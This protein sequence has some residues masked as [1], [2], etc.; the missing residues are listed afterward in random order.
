MGG[1][2]LRFS[3]L[4]PLR[5]WY[6]DDEVD[7]GRPQQRAVLAALLTASG[8]TVATSV[9]AEGVWGGAPPSEPR[10]AVQLHVSR[11]RAAFK[12]C[13]G[14]ERAG[15][16]LVRVGDGYA[17][18]A[19]DA[20][21]DAVVWDRLLA[22]AERL[23][24]EGAPADGI[25]EV[26]LRA[27]RLWDG[28]PLAG[29]A[30]PHAESVR[31][32]LLE[33]WLRAKE[34][35]L[36]MD[37]ELGDRTDLTAEAASL[38]LEHPGRPRLTA[39]LMRALYQAGRKAE[40]LAVYE[41]ARR[42]LPP[43]EP[44]AGARA[45]SGSAPV[46]DP[47]RAG[48]PV[49]VGGGRRADGPA[50]LHLRILREDPSLLPLSAARAEAPAWQ[51]PHQLP[52][53]LAD[54]TG[55]ESAVELLVDRLVGGVGR[56]VV[57]SALDGMGGV[58]K[59]TLAV[60]VARRVHER[61]PDGQLFADLRGADRAPLDPG[62]ALAR[63]LGALGVAASE[64][65]LDLGERSALYR[66]ALAGRKVLVVLDNAAGPEQVLPLLPGS[67]GCAVLITSRTRLTGLA[68]AHQMRLETLEPDEALELFT[69]IAG[70]ERVAA[71]PGL[72]EEIVAAC[73]LLPLAVRIVASRLAADPAL[74]LAA[75]SAALCDER[76][77][78]ELDDGDR[79]VEATFALSYHRLGPDLARAFRLMALPDA[80]DLSLPCAAA[81][82]GLSEAEA[83]ELL[84]AL[85]DLNL[86]HSP[87]FERYGFHDLVRDYARGRLAQEEPA[88][89]RTAAADRLVDFCLATARNADLA[90]RSVDPVEQSL[91]D[92]PVVSE[93]RPVAD[94]A[95]AVRWMREQAGV[96]AAAVHL[97]C[98]D[99]ALPLDRAAELADKMGSVLFERAQT[100]I[101]A[102]LAERI[103][104]EAAARG[105]DGPE[106]LARHVRGI[107]LWHVN[108]Y[109]ESEGEIG[110][111]VALCEGVDEGP[112]V[113]VRAKAL[114]A[115]GSNL[116]IRGRYA[117]A[118]TYAG[119]AAGLFR[120]VGAERAEGSALG[121]FAFCAAHTG[122]VEE[123]RAAAERG[124]RL[125]DGSGP[126]SAAT[127]RYYLA[128]VLR[129]CG[130][131]E[132]ALVHAV[133]ARQE[134][135]DLQITVFEA[136]TGDLVA[137][138][139]AEAGRWLL[140]AEAAEAALPLAGRTSAALEAALLRTL[141]TV[142]SGLARPR[143]ARACLQDALAVYER[144]GLGDDAVE[145][146]ALLEA[147]PQ[148]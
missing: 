19:P 63:F 12:A 44:G 10:K 80:P 33:Q 124:A 4:G 60:H 116:R 135:A 5:A 146:R 102:D 145:T 40:A 23:H 15:E 64:I 110:R 105:D 31:A 104:R 115:L 96:H 93:G 126:V 56:A 94:S 26:V 131:P 22:E 147:L 7:L 109:E 140:A 123:S 54:F 72:A 49:P 52:A 141:G 75:L 53:G 71:E 42:T 9:L 17:L 99:P 8:R 117:E 55:R 138:I 92:A 37:V 58:G 122:R 88:A 91:L 6:G 103:A 16:L 70:A 132:A 129:L 41:E 25:R 2:A 127:G 143:Q 134:F 73:G 130:D 139:H 148:P 108:R 11:L 20:E 90:A 38:A 111:A 65:P 106:A 121:E 125:M 21:V 76:R 136:A 77:L 28:Q 29:L 48:G 57:V 30:G 13:A 142:H 45:G 101:I 89:E 133:R 43:E 128:R 32:R 36:E 47:G 144:L 61:F 62:P 1:S 78:A 14:A 114:L 137:R 51:A 100:T 95:E 50:A 119:S 59:T 67:A 82:L 85:V 84:E 112:I 79:T 81:L 120:R 35:Q 87:Q 86:L 107:M 97:S 118:A 34:L 46:A 18:V 68:G 113:R 69:R 24:G 39:V 3:L 98:A 74:S 27:H 66:S 83:D